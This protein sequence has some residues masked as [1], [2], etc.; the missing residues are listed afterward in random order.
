M[1]AVPAQRDKSAE[2]VDY[3]FTRCQRDKGFAARLRRADNPST[4]YQSW[5]VL[6][7]FNINLDFAW[8]RLPYALVAASIARSGASANGRLPLGRSIARAFKGREDSDPAKMRLRRLLAC[9]KSEEACRILRPLLTLIQSK[10]SET[11]DYKGLLKD[12][13]GF[14]RNLQ[15]VKAGWATQFYRS[16]TDSNDDKSND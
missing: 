9:D 3:L 6:V 12:L 16:Q 13:L 4:E 5:E 2:F 15:R 10:V 7:K 11:L 8:E 14:N 1:T